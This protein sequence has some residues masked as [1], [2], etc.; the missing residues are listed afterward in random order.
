MSTKKILWATII[1]SKLFISLGSVSVFITS[2]LLLGSDILITPSI[3]IF[4]SVY[5]TYAINTL[6]DA[7]EDSVDKPERFSFISKYRS[8]ILITSIL[9][10]LIAVTLAAF[11]S[12][13]A[14]FSVI[15][16]VLLGIV[17]SIGC[18]PVKKNGKI[19]LKRLKD[20]PIVKNLV[21]SL[22]WA[23]TPIALIHAYHNLN[24]LV[25]TV[26][27][28]LFLFIRLF[29]NTL[30]FDVKDTEGDSK[31]GVKTVPIIW[32][33]KKTYKVVWILNILSILIIV[34]GT[35]TGY[36][37]SFAY[38]L[39]LVSLT[40]DFSVFAMKRRFFCSDK[41]CNLIVDGELLMTGFLCLIGKSLIGL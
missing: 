21:V 23:I 32:G 6:T 1:H 3:L 19:K 16:S 12:I 9:A 34:V 30:L 15:F 27:L 7:T 17:Y 26:G 2:C 39:C 38:F 18:C 25:A 40:I 35:K 29:L 5:F 36:F 10:S 37:P 28:F 41:I 24:N 14:V 4:L 22:A 8:L 33:E 20:I 11:Q 31:A 13:F